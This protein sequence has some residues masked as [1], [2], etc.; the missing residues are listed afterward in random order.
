MRGS[1]NHCVSTPG[2]GRDTPDPHRRNVAV[3]GRLREGFEGR[4]ANQALRGETRIR[5][6]VRPLPRARLAAAPA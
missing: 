4:D 2:V 6:R 3:P 5:P 1:P